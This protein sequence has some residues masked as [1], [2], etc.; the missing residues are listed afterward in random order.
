MN[1]SDY[2]QTTT[3][4]LLGAARRKPEALL[5]LA[6]GCA[7]LMRGRGTGSRSQST[8]QS[9]SRYYGERS[10]GS[11]GRSYRGSYERD[12]SYGRGA[13]AGTSRTQSA[14]GGTGSSGG[15]FDRAKEKVGDYASTVSDAA[16]T[17]SDRVSE[18][19]G[20]YAE[21]VTGFAES[22]RQTVGDYAERAG[23]TLQSGMSY[24][25]R[26]QPLA[27]ALAGVA[28]GAAVAAMFPTTEIENRNLKGARD[29]L[30]DAAEKAGE[31]LK[32]AAQ[33][34]FKNVAGE[35][36]G[37]FA[38]AF[39]GKSQE[40]GGSRG[41]QGARSGQSSSGTSERD[42]GAPGPVGRSGG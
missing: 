11:E 30:A 8:D 25:L 36:A 23:S 5:L 31:Q 42:F 39:T 40:Q 10:Y 33:E 14:G 35:V 13:Q 32:S 4:W 2:S 15:M 17:V 1:R 7:L 24:M 26:E 20:A 16:S 6:A 27:L 41:T 9:G 38:S 22:A 37:Q 34:G 28:A 12:A 19:A 18:T 3:D 29:V 21:S